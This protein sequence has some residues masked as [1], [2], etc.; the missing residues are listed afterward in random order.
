MISI[1]YQHRKNRPQFMRIIIHILM[2]LDFVDKTYLLLD[3][4]FFIHNLEIIT[5][6]LLNNIYPF[7]CKQLKQRIIVP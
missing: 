7:N 3:E 5:T 4:Q 6:I 2:N 1:I